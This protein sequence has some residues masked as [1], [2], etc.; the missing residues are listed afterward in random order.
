MTVTAKFELM[1]V[2]KYESRGLSLEKLVISIYAKRMSVSDI[3]EVCDIYKIELYT[4]AIPIITNK[5]SQADWE[6]QNRPFDPVYLI[7]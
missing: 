7:P 3:K 4:S 6:R 1:A 5:A 2:P